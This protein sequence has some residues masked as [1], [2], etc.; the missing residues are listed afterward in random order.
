LSSPL[1]ILQTDRLIIRALAADDLENCHRLRIDIGWADPR[2]SDEENRECQRSWL[3]WTINGYREFGRLHQPQYGERA[4]V[5]RTDGAFLGLIGM[6]PSLAPFAQLP[7]EGGMA[8]AR[9]TAEVGLFWALS[10]DAQGRGLATEAA[11]AFSRRLFEQL[12][13][14]RLVATTER[15]NTRSIA[16]MKRLGMRIQINPFPDPAYFQVVGILEAPA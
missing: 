11:A 12:G 16:V 4:I 8:G 10:P 5:S 13:L 2:A 6:V 3:N 15:D 1:P 14:A 7:S 9:A